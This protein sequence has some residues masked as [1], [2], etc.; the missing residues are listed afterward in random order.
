[1]IVNFSELWAADF[2]LRE[3]ILLQLEAVARGGRRTRDAAFATKTVEQS[4]KITGK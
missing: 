3:V 4:L 2:D 1:M